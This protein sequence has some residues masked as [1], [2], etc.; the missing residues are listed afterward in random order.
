MFVRCLTLVPALL[1]VAGLFQSQGADRLVRDSDEGRALAAELRA[2]RPTE[3]FT[4]AAT[5]RLR[6]ADGHVRRL[7]LTII[8][9]VG[10]SP[11][12]E[13][14]YA[15]G[16]PRPETLIM[17]RTPDRPPLYRVRT[18][19]DPTEETPGTDGSA[20]PFAGSDFTLRELGLE[21]LHWPGQRLLPRTPPPM[22]KGQACRILESTNPDAPVYTRVVSWIS[23]EHHGLMLADAY[24]ASGR[25]IKRFSIGSLKKVDGVW[26]LRDMEMID[27]VRGTETKLE[28]ELNSRE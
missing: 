11:D 28:F 13:V 16:G 25:L 24:D 7:P 10:E 3:S 20:R 17:T 12:W 23:I 27:E 22:K 15:A 2:L 19:T 6:D 1:C 5:L 9:R 14:T 18:G 26:Q 21:F 4:N 8:N